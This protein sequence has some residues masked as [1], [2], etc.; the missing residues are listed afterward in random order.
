VIDRKVIGK[1]VLIGWSGDL[2]RVAAL[3]APAW[4]PLIRR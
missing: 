1:A 4:Q 2:V 3:H